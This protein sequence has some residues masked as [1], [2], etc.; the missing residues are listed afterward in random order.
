[1]ARRRPASLLVAAT[2]E[3]T[4]LR[5]A[6]RPTGRLLRQGDMDAS[7]VDLADPRHLE[8]DYLRWTAIVLEAAGARDIVHVGGAGCALARALAAARGDRR[9]EVIEVD[10]DVVELARAHLGLRRAPG[11]RVR[12][13]DGRAVLARRGDATAD[14]VVLDAFVGARVPRHLVTA[15]ALAGVARVLRPGGVAVVNVVDA[16]GLP[17]TRAIA[18]GLRGAL[19]AV[20][21]LAAA[22]VAHGRHGGNV[23]LLAARAPFGLERIRSR[24]A[25]DPSPALLLEPAEVAALSATAAPWRDEA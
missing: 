14:A 23:V 18:A 20:A 11:L 3:L 24:A 10:P 4:V 15:E 7:Y 6:E 2:G 12:T 8:F 22:P 13:G 9:Q 17:D 19:G 1:M 16:R 5:D 25:A 21:A